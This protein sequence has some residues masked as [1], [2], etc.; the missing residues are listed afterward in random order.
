MTFLD[1]ATGY[2]DVIL[3]RDRSNASVAVESFI[4]KAENTSSYTLKRL[5][6]DNEFKTRDIEDLA[7]KKG[8]VIT[9]SAPYTP[10]Q[11]GAGERI[12]RT[13]FNKV[14]ALLTGSNLAL[15]YWNEALL[16][17]V[18]L[19]NR[20]PHSSYAF[21]TPYEVRF[22]KKPN[23]GHIKTWGSLVYKKEPKEL[24][25]KLDPRA[26]AHYLIGYGSNQYRLL[27]PKTSK[28]TN[29]RDV[30]ILENRFYKDKH[31]Q[32]SLEDISD[33][34]SN[35]SIRGHADSLKN[36]NDDNSDTNAI[37]N[38][39]DI[40]PIRAR[41][42]TSYEDFFNQLVE[43]AILNTSSLDTEPTTLKE[44][45]Q[46][47]D[48]NKYIEAIKIELEG[49]E[50][51]NTWTLV[52]RPK[53]KP[54]LK[55]RLVFK[56][57]LKA[58]GDLDKYKARYVVKGYLQQYGVNFTE[59]FA[60]TTKPISLRL[61]L[62]I[63]TMLD[64]EVYKGDVKQAFAVP[65]IDTEI[66]LEQPPFY[67]KDKGLV[68][69]LNKALYG[70]KQAARQWQEHMKSIL[71]KLG[72]RSLISD[73]S[74]YLDQESGTILAIYVDGI[75]VFAKDTITIDKLFRDLQDRDLDITNLGPIKEFLGIEIQRDIKSKSLYI[76][77]RGYIQR[78]LERY[79][80][81]NLKGLEKPYREG[82]IIESNIGTATK[83]E[84]TQYQKE[85]GA[86]IYLTIY[87]R[88]DLSFRVGQSAG[89]MPNPSLDHFK[90]LD[91][92]WCYLNNTKS[93]AIG[94]KLQSCP[95]L[96]TTV[97][98]DSDWGGDLATRKFC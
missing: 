35:L 61:L 64:L 42:H 22:N 49:L 85:I 55:G 72:F 51:N 37:N 23:L 83:E 89:F 20:T 9:T 74:I 46:H 82:R 77:Q 15:K 58:N 44:V 26:T 4:N 10:E 80:K 78:L 56:K 79:N 75:L 40:E 52:P 24:I 63:A 50:K 87:T 67:N 45:L 66:Y 90:A 27:D 38:V 84:I 59:T 29:A 65:S 30:Y 92:I 71:S 14:R 21:R 25:G 97:Y 41:E 68:C 34:D 88:P 86:L 11:K 6:C 76:T 69:R 96:D 36:N 91:N 33:P 47:H 54:V 70:L 1:A 39:E 19:Y 95:V 93:Y 48:K 3:L 31:N 73:N 12:N 60:S 53:D 62:G 32:G 2:L 81:M 57:K 18:H 17:A 94:F 8:F 16:S 43:N 5:H 98:T 28:I 7:L 13:L